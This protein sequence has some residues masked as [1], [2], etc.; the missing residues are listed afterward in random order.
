ME[1]FAARAPL[2]RVEG[3]SVRYRQKRGFLQ[4]VDSVDLQVAPGETLGIVGESGCGKTSL[5]K[6][7]I[8]LVEAD[9]GQVFLEEQSLLDLPEP[10]WRKLRRHT[11]II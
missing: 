3:L 2:L 9:R 8:R 7:I 10:S 11:Q 6:A 5:G 1:D 4:A